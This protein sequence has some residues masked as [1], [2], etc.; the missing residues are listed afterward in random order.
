M[1]ISLECALHLDCGSGECLGLSALFAPSDFY[2]AL[3]NLQFPGFDHRLLSE[4]FLMIASLIP[5]F[6][7]EVSSWGVGGDTDCFCRNAG[8]CFDEAPLSLSEPQFPLR[9]R[10]E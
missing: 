7:Q 3:R 8:I 5:E 10:L 2:Q 6:V 9:L 1:A 4:A